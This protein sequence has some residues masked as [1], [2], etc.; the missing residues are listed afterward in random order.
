MASSN[1]KSSAATKDK[2]SPPPFYIE[3]ILRD[4]KEKKETAGAD[5]P[6]PLLSAPTT[7]I[8][9]TPSGLHMSSLTT[10]AN[11]FI[12]RPFPGTLPLLSC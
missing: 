4:T 5:H 2:K 12:S 11:S 8:S 3:G 6:A 1:E 9:G 7:G 10:P